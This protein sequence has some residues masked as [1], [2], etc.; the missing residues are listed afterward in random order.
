M[1]PSERTEEGPETDLM[2]FFLNYILPAGLAQLALQEAMVRES[3][4]DPVL[5]KFAIRG[6]TSSSGQQESSGKIFRF[7]GAPLRAAL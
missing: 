7:C 6:I 4:E 1:R 5:Q 2:K 3:C